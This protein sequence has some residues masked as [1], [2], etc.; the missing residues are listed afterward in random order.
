[1][2]NRVLSVGFLVGVVYVGYGL[3]HFPPWQFHSPRLVRQPGRLLW[4]LPRLWDDREWTE[5]GLRFRR[6]FFRWQLG[7]VALFVLAFLL[8]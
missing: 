4:T 1:M 7:L 3:V 5:E 6:A 2:T 8:L